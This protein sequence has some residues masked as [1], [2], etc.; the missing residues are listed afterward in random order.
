MVSYPDIEK[1]LVAYFN[2]ALGAEEITVATKHSQPDEDNPAAQLVIQASY[3]R[4]ITQVTR[5][6]NITLDVY[7]DSY[8]E[9]NRLALLVETLSKEAASGYIKYAEVRLGPVRTTEESEQERRS[10]DVLMILKG[11]DL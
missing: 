4:T 2:T 9:A 10:L 11:Y 7:A 8:A 1:L 3:G 5:E 6:V